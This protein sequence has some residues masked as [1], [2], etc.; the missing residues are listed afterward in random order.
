MD[1]F[2]FKGKLTQQDAKLITMHQRFIAFNADAPD[3]SG[4]VRGDPLNR[5]L[6]ARI[7]RTGQLDNGRILRGVDLRDGECV[8]Q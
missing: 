8:R 2:S 3:V 7:R 5:H 1:G 4:D 6:T